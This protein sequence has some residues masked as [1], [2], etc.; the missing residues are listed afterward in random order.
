MLRKLLIVSCGLALLLAV[1][2]NAKT[3]YTIKPG[4]VLEY[5]VM[6][7]T[8][9]H[10]GNQTVK[11]VGLEK[12]RNRS[13]FRIRSKVTSAGLVNQLTGYTE[14]E[15]LLLDAEELYPLYLR[16]TVLEKKKSKIEEVSFD[17]GKKIA[18][19]VYSK[20]GGPNEQTQIKL[21]GIVHDGLSLQYFFRQVELKPGQHQLYFYSNGK[22]KTISYSV[23]EVNSK[24]EL[25]CGIFSGYLEVQSPGVNITLLLANNAERYPLVI[26]K[27]SDIGKFEAKLQKVF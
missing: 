3:T 11:V 26:R 16:R 15:E 24:L 6:V 9:I 22:V 10:G 7:K 4:E 20:N 12:Y 1:E 27:L 2:G 19:R 17:Y 14:T 23:Q 18:T 21:P 25:D 8:L 13:V 5:K